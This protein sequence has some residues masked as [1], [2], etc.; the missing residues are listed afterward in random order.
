[1][2]TEEVMYQTVE[3]V[4]VDIDLG[5]KT[6]QSPTNFSKCAADFAKLHQ[7]L[8]D[9]ERELHQPANYNK[10]CQQLTYINAF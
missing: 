8:L 10:G 7:T 3:N 9:T 5:L 1:M 4:L 2:D 6:Q